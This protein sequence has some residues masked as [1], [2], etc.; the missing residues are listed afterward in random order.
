MAAS[1]EAARWALELTAQA[2]VNGTQDEAAFAGWLA[3]RLADTLGFTRV[4]TIPVRDDPLGRAAVAALAPGEGARTVLLTGHF[5]TVH[6]EDYGDLAPLAFRPYELRAALI[7]RLATQAAEPAAALALADLR[8]G[9]FLPGRGLLDMKAGLAAGLAAIRAWAVDEHRQGKLLFLAVPDEEGNSAGARAVVEAL[10]AELQRMGLGLEAA[11]NLDA[12][13]DQGDGAEGRRA[14]LGT[15]GKLLPTAL[16]VGRPAHAAGTLGG[17]NAGALAGALASAVEWAPELVDRAGDDVAAPPTLLGL[18]DHRPGYDVTTPE[19]V[20]AYWNVMTLSRSPA[21]VLEAMANLTRGALVEALARLRARG[22]TALPEEVPV[23]TFA[24][25]A[26]EVRGWQAPDLP[27]GLDLP[28]RCRRLTEALWRQSGRPGP[29][30][31]LGFGSMPYLPASLAGAGGDRLEGAVRRATAKTA[32]RHGTTIG[33][34]GH[35][36]GIS[37]MSFLGQVDAS[38]VAAIAANTPAWDHGIDWPA[39]APSLG[40]PAINI[41]PWGRDYHTP[42]ERLHTPYAFGVLPDL[43]LAAAREFLGDTATP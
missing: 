2:S 21:A 31:V 30:V 6:V 43:L 38:G 33:C 13:L 3:G 35:F 24:D 14:A 4:W 17:V 7:E 8:S 32:A 23:L 27:Q 5:D 37:D 9:E 34:R 42:L 36:P 1:E 11:I 15:V 26:A 12:M 25:L 40:V 22:G 28:E 19:R 20:W 29:A 39:G 16:V 41:G 10:P 18:A